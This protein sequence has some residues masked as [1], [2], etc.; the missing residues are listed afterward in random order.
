MKAD[1]ISTTKQRT[2]IITRILWNVL[3]C[4]LMR[5]LRYWIRPPQY[6]TFLLG[7]YIAGDIG[8][9]PLT[10][11]H[12]PD[13]AWAM[14]LPFQCIQIDS[15]SHYCGD[16]FQMRSLNLYLILI[17]L[18]FAHNSAIH[19]KSVLLSATAWQHTSIS[20]IARLFVQITHGYALLSIYI[21]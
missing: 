14:W 16:H 12:Q 4:I 19:T 11:I 13:M 1:T 2:R 15:K 3:Y 10:I 9:R 17:C 8:G 7:L 18:K 20:V 21:I 5:Y 6:I